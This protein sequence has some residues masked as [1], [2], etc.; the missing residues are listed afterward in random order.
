MNEEDYACD[1]FVSQRWKKDVCKICFQPKRL[2]E[3]KTKATKKGK[4]DNENTTTQKSTVASAALTSMISTDTKTIDKTDALASKKHIEPEQQQKEVNLEPKGATVVPEEQLSAKSQESRAIEHECSMSGVEPQASD[5]VLLDVNTDEQG[6]MDDLCAGS[7]TNVI[8]VKYD[9]ETE[10]STNV[11]S[12]DND[13]KRDDNDRSVTEEHK[14]PLDNSDGD[15][16]ITDTSMCNTVEGSRGNGEGA[17]DDDIDGVVV[18]EHSNTSHVE[19]LP[20]KPTSGGAGNEDIHKEA[21]TS[22]LPPVEFT[23]GEEPSCSEE[24][25]D[26]SGFEGDTRATQVEDNHSITT[27]IT[28]S[29]LLTSSLQDDAVPSLSAEKPQ[30]LNVEETHADMVCDDDGAESPSAKVE[31]PQSNDN[32]DVSSANDPA[33]PTLAAADNQ[34][35]PMV[36]NDHGFNIP[37]PPSPPPIRPP[38][39]CP[40]LLA[41]KEPS[42]D[43][44]GAGLTT[45]MLTSPQVSSCFTSKFSLCY[46]KCSCYVFCMEMP[47][48]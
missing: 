25:P 1:K 18:V 42:A 39:P 8:V 21:T 36:V 38:P 23:T 31:L 5:K 45:E 2:H 27:N 30:Q 48:V 9:Q 6:T 26:E 33:P 46:L 28:T 15:I 40:P 13:D 47:L 17:H 24:L 34:A 19:E 37:V 14:T 35:P 44:P 29:T 16:R 20:T 41:D 11:N 4:V 10:H 43:P 22:T 32:D 12:L 7:S 3:L